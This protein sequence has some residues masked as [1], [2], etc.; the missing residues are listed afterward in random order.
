MFYDNEIVWNWTYDF[1][2]CAKKLVEEKVAGVL[3]PIHL[4]SLLQP[5]PLLFPHF[6][7]SPCPLSL[8]LTSA[9]PQS[10]L[11][12]FQ[13]EEFIPKYISILFRRGVPQGANSILYE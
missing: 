2:S 9:P 11:I 6:P 8:S 3:L 13:K 5:S 12:H 7:F 1:N 10:R 4:L